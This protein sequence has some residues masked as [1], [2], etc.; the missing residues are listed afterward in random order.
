MAIHVNITADNV[1]LLRQEIM[2]LA[3]LFTVPV[4][5][6]PPVVNEEVKPVITQERMEENIANAPVHEEPPVPT[7]EEVRA[8]LK[9]LRDK[10][11]A[12]AVKEILKEYGADS[13]PELKEEDYL[14]VRDRALAEV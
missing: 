7:L 5:A 1:F 9:K 11:G 12:T 4:E 10:K 8:A 14:I 13:L 2:G 3:D 6:T